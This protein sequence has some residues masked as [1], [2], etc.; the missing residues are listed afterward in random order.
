MNSNKKYAFFLFLVIILSLGACD[1]SKNSEDKPHEK[2]IIKNEEP[3]LP[4]IEQ[5]MIEQGLINI[6]EI[7]SSIHVELKYSTTDN[8]FGEDV[9]DD[10]TQAYLQPKTAQ[11]LAL[12]NK[13]L[14]DKYPNYRLL[15]YDAARPLSIQEVLWQ[16][17][18]SIPPKKRSDFVADP[19]KGS[20]HNFG[21]AVDLTI[22]NITTNKPLD[23]GTKYDYFGYLAYPRKE[24]E[25]LA[26]GQ[27]TT[28]QVENRHI[29]RD[30]MVA[31]GFM[32]ITSE[33]WHFNAKSREDAKRIY[34]IIR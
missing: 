5:K 14:K 10:M 6:Q 33:W 32:P 1:N 12:S 18:D 8:F 26:T 28:L 11:M 31:S 22:V 9:Y 21:C 4:T 7:D 27:L 24:A 23:M 17:L 29:L 2:E 3:F 16:K 15:V 25:M 19:A 30:V 20:I 13:I 34:K